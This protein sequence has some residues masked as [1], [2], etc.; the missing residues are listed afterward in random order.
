M[1]RLGQPPPSPPA[2][3]TSL[4]R[5]LPVIVSNFSIIRETPLLKKIKFFP[6]GCFCSTR[7]SGP[8]V[9]VRLHDLLVCPCA[10]LLLESSFLSFPCY[11]GMVFSTPA[12]VAIFLVTPL[13]LELPDPNPNP[14][15]NTKNKLHLK[16]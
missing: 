9:H 11:G 1:C 8:S 14:K 13:G 4:N 16:K 6:S 12:P 7:V 2:L 10:C 3:A 5:R 15:P